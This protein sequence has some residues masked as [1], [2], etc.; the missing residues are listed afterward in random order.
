M[1]RLPASSSV[2]AAPERPGR[3]APALPAALTGL[4]RA[5]IPHACPGCGQQLGRA[6]GLCAPCRAGLHARIETH[7]PLRATPAPHLLTLGR[8]AG[9]N[10]RAVRDLKFTG[11]R[12]LAGVLGG[13]LADGLPTHW[14]IQAVIPVP[15]HAA[16]QRQR[17]FNQ[18]DLLARAIA[19]PHGLPVHAALTRTRA[20]R[21]QARQHAA[22]RDDLQGAFTVNARQLLRG[23]LLLVDDVLTTGRT[24][25][26]CRDALL[27]AGVA[28]DDLSYA[29]IAR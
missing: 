15:L 18:A 21:Q 16:R 13:A 25:I 28:P 11:A 3:P 24:L 9:V 7:S 10:R 2:S 4:L 1:T 22:D 29:V 6:A 14:N 19:R 27:Q 20:T 17:G 8:Y 26:A 5:L 23:P 12:D